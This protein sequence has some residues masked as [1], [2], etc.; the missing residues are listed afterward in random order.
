VRETGAPCVVS[1]QL[2]RPITGGNRRAIALAS[3]IFALLAPALSHVGAPARWSRLD[4]AAQLPPELHS[5]T[6]DW[7]PGVARPALIMGG[8]AFCITVDY[9]DPL[10][11]IIRAKNRK[12]ELYRQRCDRCWLAVVLA[13]YFEVESVGA[14]A[15]GL[16]A[17]YE[18]RFERVLLIDL[19]AERFWS[20]K[21]KPQYTGTQDTPPVG[22]SLP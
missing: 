19:S 14:L 1:V 8:E 11:E 13:H 15:P 22:Q 3:E 6:L 9:V 2:M 18:A 20:V 5:L 4:R 17:E 12:Y 21:T 10:R 16:V 7:P